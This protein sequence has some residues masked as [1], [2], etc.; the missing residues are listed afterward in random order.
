[1]ATPARARKP[2]T[3]TDLDHA[4]VALHRATLAF[5]EQDADST[6]TL[7]NAL[8]LLIEVTGADAGAVAV[9]GGPDGRPLLLAE[10][11][12]DDAGPVSMTVLEKTLNGAASHASLIDPPPSTSVFGAGITSIL[13]TPVRR[14]G[15]TLAAVYLDRRE[16]EPF[17]ESARTVAESFAT[18]LALA[19][20]LTRKAE[21]SEERAEEA[22]AVAV[23]AG[24]FWRFGE[25]VTKSRG[26]AECLRRAERAAGSDTTLL[27]LGETGSGKEH[28]ARCVH[29]ESPRRKGPFVVVNCAAVPENLLESELFGHER[30][31]F[32]GATETRRGK[33][34]LADGGTLFLDE[35]GEMPL[36]LQ[37]KLLRVLEDHKLFRVGGSSEK[38]MNVRIL[39][40]TNRDLS[41]E[42]ELGR[43][44]EDLYYRL[45]VLPL[46]LPPLRERP[47][48]I[49]P[50]AKRFLEVEVKRTGRKLR[51]TQAAL[52]R[53][54]QERWPGN[55]RQLRNTVE[56][57][58]VLVTG[59]GISLED[60]ESHV[61]KQLVQ[62]A[63]T[64]AA[65]P[66]TRWKERVKRAERKIQNLEE[67]FAK[68]EARSAVPELADATA[69]P[70][71]RARTYQQRIEDAGGQI[72]A[73]ALREAGSIAAA[74]RLLG[75]SR[76]SLWR[77]CKKLGLAKE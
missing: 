48:D 38:Q 26:F 59:P 41:R 16:R 54:A 75:L 71:D 11:F 68:L 30:G 22:R 28:L 14:R 47:E 63:P 77:R 10:R 39:A 34:E 24:G 64:P 18:M 15:E 36:H 65:L 35:I 53:L 25:L 21:R 46:Q 76:Q 32:T 45:N 52:H 27:M 19:L 23:H 57:L 42:I 29:E 33:F 69:A 5:A 56:K 9:P 20:D 58:C 49:A 50:L 74:A 17:D 61:F 2:S 37:P 3:S 44:R 60:L 66:R 13:C 31:A 62:E 72:I 73:E 43:F 12:M 1:M 40:A 70:S 67:R 55:V 4:L 6:E 51:W 8:E 7:R